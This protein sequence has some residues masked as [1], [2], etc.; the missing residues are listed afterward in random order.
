[1][2]EIKYQPIGIIHTPHEEAEGTPIQPKGAK[3]IKGEVEVYSE[4]EEG[5]KDLEGFSHV[6]LLF[7]CHLSGNYS[8]RQEPYMDDDEHGIFA[9]RGP[10]RPNPIGLSV[11]KL[12]SVEDN[13]LK[14]ENVDI[15]DETPLLDIKPF[16][17][18]FDQN[19]VEKIGWLGEN[20]QKLSDTRDDGRFLERDKK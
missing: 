7:H 14:I 9:M 19:K 11:V 2:N 5:L 15:I 17:P 18:E 10:S 20:I 3:G 16:V 12:N 13:I 6:I 4:Y 1:M 8:L